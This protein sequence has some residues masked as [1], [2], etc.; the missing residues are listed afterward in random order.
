MHCQVTTSLQENMFMRQTGRV[1]QATFRANSQNAAH[2]GYQIGNNSV[3]EGKLQEKVQRYRSIIGHTTS[4]RL[5]IDIVHRLIV[6]ESNS[7]SVLNRTY[8]ESEKLD[9]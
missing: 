3:I 4:K 2:R 7:Y 8:R 5:I 6:D 9:L 1:H